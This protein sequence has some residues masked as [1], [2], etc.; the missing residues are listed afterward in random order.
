[1]YQIDK[2]QLD[3]ITEYIFL[4]DALRPADVIF[5]PGC[6]RPEHTEKLPACTGKGMRLC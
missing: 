2:K 6:N 5:I 1:M 3:D 4:R